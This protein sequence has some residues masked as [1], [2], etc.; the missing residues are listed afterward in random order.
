MTPSWRVVK[1]GGSLLDWPRLVPEFRRWLARQSRMADVVIVGGGALVDVVRRFDSRHALAPAA[2]HWMSIRAM[3]LTAEWF[4]HL[5]GDTTVVSSLGSLDPRAQSVQVLAVEQF[6]RC[7]AGSPAALPCGWDVTSDSIAAR[8]AAAMG[9]GELAV[10]KSTLPAGPAHSW[11]KAGF[12]DP[13][14]ARVAAGLNVRVVNLRDP[15]FPQVT[16]DMRATD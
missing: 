9:A 6:L 7:D 8:V 11:A 3:N 5:L 4:A 16:V 10:L 2:A 12:V 14:F 1:L 13:C 15:N